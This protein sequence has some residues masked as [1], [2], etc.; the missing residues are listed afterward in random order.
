MRQDEIIEKGMM[1]FPDS[2]LN[3]LD[4]K[5]KIKVNTKSQVPLVLNV[6]TN[7]FFNKPIETTTEYMH[8]KKIS[9][10]I[11]EMK[12]ETTQTENMIKL[13]TCNI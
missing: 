6:T 2:V 3:D 5:A 9:E 4:K 13:T 11:K 10:A 8:S 12:T 1:E 7:N